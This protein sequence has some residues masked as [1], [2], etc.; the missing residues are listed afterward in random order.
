MHSYSTKTKQQVRMYTCKMVGVMSALGLLHPSA[1]SA[2]K[3]G[4]I[5]KEADS[6]HKQK[7]QQLQRSWQAIECYH[8]SNKC[9][10]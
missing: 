4:S 1:A 5:C 10:S 9:S 2:A 3:I 7:R 8:K 6:G